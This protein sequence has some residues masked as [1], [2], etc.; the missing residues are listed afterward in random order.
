MYCLI[1]NG[2]PAPSD[3]D[4]YLAG[5]AAELQRR[6]QQVR[7]I[8]L[9]GLHLRTCVGC[10]SCWWKTPGLC[11]LKDDMQS[12]YPE[13]VKADLVVWASPLLMGTV[14]ALLKTAQD[15][16]VPIAHPYIEIVNGEC[17]HRHRYEHNADIGLIVQPTRDDTEE[18][19]AITR[20][21]YERFSLNT[22]TRMR[23]CAV[24]TTTPCEE[25]AHAALAA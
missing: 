12:L 5:F 3:F 4:D 23:V 16:F 24:T 13:M 18:D 20:Q 19:L 6:G 21:L 2:N 17:H 11:A 10:W 1:L 14:S 9:R 7:R 25:A 22:R 15:R 8:D